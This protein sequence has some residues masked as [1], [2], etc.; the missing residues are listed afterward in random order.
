LSN[1]DRQI[2]VGLIILTVLIIV[3]VI[4]IHFDIT[5]SQLIDFEELN[6]FLLSSRTLTAKTRH[7]SQEIGPLEQRD[8]SVFTF[9]LVNGLGV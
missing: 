2:E 3:L 7:T 4:V 6:L 8:I 5:T 1:I 9:F